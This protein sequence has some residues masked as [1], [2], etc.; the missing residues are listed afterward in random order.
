MAQ[1]YKQ[2]PIAG[3]LTGATTA[4][5]LKSGSLVFKMHRL[6]CEHA[7][8]PSTHA[9]YSTCFYCMHLSQTAS[10]V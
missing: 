7:P 10:A 1:V 2:T 4:I 3:L 6:L 9:M 5:F 8:Y